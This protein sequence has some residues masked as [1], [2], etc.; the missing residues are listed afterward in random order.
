MLS[1]GWSWEENPQTLI[2]YSLALF[3][4]PLSSSQ[5]MYPSWIVH[6]LDIPGHPLCLWHCAWYQ[7]AYKCVTMWPLPSGNRS[8]LCFSGESNEVADAVILE[9]CF[10]CAKLPCLINDRLNFHQVLW[11]VLQGVQEGASFQP[12]I[13]IPC[14]YALASATQEHN[15]V[16]FKK[17]QTQI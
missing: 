10:L 12:R 16:N 3:S 13:V 9:D 11:W 4:A 15:E 17:K 7:G 1:Q 2:Y 14:R 5:I 8:L 6:L